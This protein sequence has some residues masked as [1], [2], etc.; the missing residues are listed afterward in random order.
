[1]APST[2]AFTGLTGTSAVSH[3]AKVGSSGTCTFV[4][5]TLSRRAAADA[6]STTYNP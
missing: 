6:G 3:A 5:A 1:M 4:A 2:A